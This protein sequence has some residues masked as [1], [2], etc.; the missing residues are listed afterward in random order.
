MALSLT[1]FV[2]P[3]NLLTEWRAIGAK[4]ALTRQAWSERVV[5]APEALRREFERRNEGKLPDGWRG[6]TLAWW[7]KSGYEYRATYQERQ[8]SKLGRMARLRGNVEAV[9]PLT[10]HPT[11]LFNAEQRSPL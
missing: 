6:V 8:R 3:E 5:R 1:P 10:K 9:S 11:A 4:G 7:R 2:I